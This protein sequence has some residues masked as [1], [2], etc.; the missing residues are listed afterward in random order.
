MARMFALSAGH[1][2]VVRKDLGLERVRK[3]GMEEQREAPGDLGCS[4]L[5]AAGWASGAQIWLFDFR[6][7]QVYGLV[8]GA[9]GGSPYL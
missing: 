9:G 1:R 6:H 3:A 8:A 7:W 4:D 2:G 5:W